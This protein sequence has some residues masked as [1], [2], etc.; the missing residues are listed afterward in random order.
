MGW[1]GVGGS[2]GG[3][4]ARFGWVWVGLGGCGWVWVGLGGFG[5]VG[6]AGWG[7]WVAGAGSGG[8]W[9]L[10]QKCAR[11]GGRGGGSKKVNQK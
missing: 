1:L 11:V 3:S 9:A 10:P 5:W 8:R 2:V 6:W 4:V 7:C